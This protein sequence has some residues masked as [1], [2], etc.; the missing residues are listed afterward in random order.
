MDDAAKAA[1]IAAVNGALE[2]VDRLAASPGPMNT[3]QLAT[4]AACIRQTVALLVNGVPE[5]VAEPEPVDPVEDTPP[6]GA[7]DPEPEAQA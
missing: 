3:A 1:L 4:V 6:V 5:P 7:D 2:P